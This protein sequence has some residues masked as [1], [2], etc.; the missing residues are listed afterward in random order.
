MCARVCVCV[1]V[2]GALMS[3][4]LIW[5]VT[6]ILVYL[7]V[8]RVMTGDYEIGGSTMLITAGCAVAFNIL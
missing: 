3:V 2:M 6:A 5:V 1:E 4:L 8:L 7:A